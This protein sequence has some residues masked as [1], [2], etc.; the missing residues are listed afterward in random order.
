MGS[1]MKPLRAR[2]AMETSR[3][4]LQK[5]GVRH[6]AGRP[7]GRVI[8]DR[9][10]GSENGRYTYVY[11]HGLALGVTTPRSRRQVVF[12]APRL[13]CDKKQSVLLVTQQLRRDDS[14]ARSRARGR[15]FT[16][17]KSDTLTLETECLPSAPPQEC[18]AAHL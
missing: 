5:V 15:K 12:R 8:H 18:C 7:L 2:P 17:L 16:L 6:C 3:R 13:D 14:D 10:K 4:A 9:A 1:F 11:L